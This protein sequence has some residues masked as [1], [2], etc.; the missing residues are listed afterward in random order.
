MTPSEPPPPSGNS[1]A[2]KQRALIVEDNPTNQA[3]VGA[4]MQSLDFTV[5]FAENGQEALEVVQEAEFDIILMDIHMPIKDGFEA[6]KEIRALGG[7]CADVPIIAVTANE[8]AKDKSIY[9]AA[10]LDD[11]VPKPLD[12]RAFAETVLRHVSK[13]SE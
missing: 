1:T 3:V 12:T 4:V 9:L 11:M 5:A 8:M 13:N 2:E 6:T 10:G 7:W